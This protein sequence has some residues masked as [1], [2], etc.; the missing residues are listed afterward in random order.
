MAPGAWWHHLLHRHAPCAAS[1]QT[2][3]LQNLHFGAKLRRG[4]QVSWLFPPFLCQRATR[5]NSAHLTSHGRSTSALSS[6]SQYWMTEWRSR[7]SL[8]ENWVCGPTAGRGGAPL[9]LELA[10]A[11]SIV[12]EKGGKPVTSEE[13]SRCHLRQVIHALLQTTSTWP[14]LGNIIDKKTLQGNRP[15]LP[16]AFMQVTQ[17]FICKKISRCTFQLCHQE[18]EE[19]TE[20]CVSLW[21]WQLVNLLMRQSY[22]NRKW[23]KININAIRKSRE[24]KVSVKAFVIV[25]ITLK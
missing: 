17:V 14:L 20:K 25:Y 4:G 9:L 12:K 19:R 13:P 16:L 11:S 23:C 5:S 18:G 2:Q 21:L 6:V 10:L 1:P 24:T 3:C 22:E 8:V 15:W 7:E